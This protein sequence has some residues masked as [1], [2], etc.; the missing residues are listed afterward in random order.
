MV[1]DI[2]A[3]LSGAASEAIFIGTTVDNREIWDVPFRSEIARVV[4]D[5]ESNAI[6]TLYKA[7]G[8]DND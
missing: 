7:G 2:L 3:S 4:Y 6:V 1:Y 8:A 5:P